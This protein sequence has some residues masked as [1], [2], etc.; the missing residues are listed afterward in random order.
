MEVH[1]H[2]HTPDP[3]SHRGRKKW[4]HYFWEFLMLFLAVTLGFFVENQREHYIEHKREKEYIRSLV[5]DL[6][7]DTANA[8]I[9]LRNNI[10]KFKGLDTLIDLLKSDRPIDSAITS[11]LYDLSY[12][13]GRNMSLV[14]TNE[15]TIQQLLSSGNVRL[16]RKKGVYDSLVSYQLRRN[17]ISRLANIYEE[18]WRKSYSFHDELL[19]I[20]GYRTII[21]NSDTSFTRIYN[22]NNLKLIS[23]EKSKLNKYAE[24]TEALRAVISTYINSLKLLKQSAFNLLVFLKKEYHLE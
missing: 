6:R 15:I 2:A 3:D 7:K 9:H 23:T 19:K 5:T 24:A 16:L 8:S 10:L 14:I 11:Q 20:R 13:Y 18:Y 17:Q 21:M 4:T 12:G 22:H 1:H